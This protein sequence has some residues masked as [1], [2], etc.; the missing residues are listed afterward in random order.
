MADLKKKISKAKTKAKRDAHRLAKV[1]L[2]E[3]GKKG[4]EKGKKVKKGKPAAEEVLED[5]S[6]WE[7]A[8][9][10]VS[11]VSPAEVSP[12]EVSI[13]RIRGSVIVGTEFTW[14]GAARLAE[15]MEEAI[16]DGSDS[17]DLQ[18]LRHRLLY[19]SVS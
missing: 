5:D 2:V 19:G 12:A 16:A 8:D 13:Q 14:V 11:A 4:K 3:K 6:N 7:E 15:F 9:L 10:V 17:V 18:Q 1:E